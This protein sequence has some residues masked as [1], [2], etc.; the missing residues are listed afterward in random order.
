M[1]SAGANGANYPS[2]NKCAS[3]MVRSN[4]FLYSCMHFLD[5]RGWQV[6]IDVMLDLRH[7]RKYQ[8]VVTT[9]EYLSLQ[10]LDPSLERSN[11]AWA[12]D[13][14]HSGPQDPTLGVIPNH[15]YDPSGVVRVDRLVETAEKGGILVDSPVTRKMMDI[16][17]DQLAVKFVDVKNQIGN[18]AKFSSDEELQTI[19]EE[20]GWAIV[21]TFAG[22]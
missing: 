22:A 16:K 7:L 15:D 19:L 6:P 14:Y 20:H 13:A 2:R 10:G 3:L 21:Y 12:R 1:L 18:A 8:A 9:G 5:T 4:Q 17:G 11:G